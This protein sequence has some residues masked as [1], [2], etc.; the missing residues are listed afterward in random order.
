MP[1]MTG[2]QAAIQALASEGV[3]H[4]F[5]IPGIH[6]LALFDAL[7][8]APDIQR[9]TA[10]HEQGAAYMADGYARASGEVGVCLISTGPGA[11]NSLAA[12]G[13]A[14]ADSSPVLNIFTD[15]PSTT[16]DSDK[17]YLHQVRYQRSMFS[18]VTGWSATPGKV[19]DIPGLVSEAM[20]RMRTGRA[21]PAAIELPKDLLDDTADVAFAP[22]VP[23]APLPGDAADVT[24]VADALLAARRPLIW[25]G[26]GVVAAGAAAELTR[27]AETLR[28]PV[29]TSIL[30]KGTIPSDHPLHLGSQALQSPVQEYID[31][32]DLLLAIGTRFT[33]IETAGWTLRLPQT[34]VQIDVDPAEI[35]RNY[36]ASLAVVGDARVVL[37]QLLEIVGQPSDDRPDRSREVAEVR[38]V[39]RQALWERSE[40]SVRLMDTVTSVLP[41]GAII[42]NDVCTPAYWGWMMLEVDRPRLYIYPWGFGTLGAGLPLA[43]GAKV[44]RP[45]S[46]VLAVCGDG[47]F[48]YTA[49]ELATA[50]QFGI[51][52]VALIVNDNRYGIL[53][54]QQITRFGRTTMTELRSPDFVSLAQS[55]GARGVSV[56]RVEDV[57]PALADAIAARSP[58]VVEF[59]AVL[60]HPFEW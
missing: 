11:L 52:V 46:T 33:E 49:T 55:F 42:A 50:A 60:P 38:A 29:I 59:R 28:V 44:A 10:R 5:G 26:G 3:R 6:G 16:L 1:Q 53:E 31:G 51:N 2:G 37:Q 34:L 20:V 56:D 17:G 30:G 39:V 47:G 25:A 48:L 22:K 58:A 40:E 13:T 24:A 15:V 32:C 27:L 9:I 19:S 54:P 7:H 12:M 35:G 18:G 4:I 57:G 36:P 8:D 21:R 23:P 43:I 45:D 14:F 41:P